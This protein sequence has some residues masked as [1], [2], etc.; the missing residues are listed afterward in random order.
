MADLELTT[1][2]RTLVVT[3]NRPARRNAVDGPTAA[4]L[5]QAFRAFDADDALDVAVLT[6]ADGTFCAGADLKAIAEGKGN[7][8]EHAGDGPMGPTR[9][10]LSKPA[11]AAIE[12]FAVAGGLELATWCDLRVAA[13][14]AVLGVFCRRWGVPLVDLGTVRL[15]RLIGHSRAIDMILTGRGVGAPEALSMGLVNRVVPDGTALEA[16]IELAA[17]LSALPQRCLRSDRLSAI[18]QW[19]LAEADATTNEVDHGLEVLRSGEAIEGAGRFAAGAG[20]HGASELGGGGSAIQHGDALE[21]LGHLEEVEGAECRDVEPDVEE[22]SQVTR[23]RRRVAR[24]RDDAADRR[25]VAQGSEHASI[26]ATSRRIEHDVGDVRRVR[27]DGT[28]ANLGRDD[29]RPGLV[30][31][32]PPRVGSRAARTVD[33]EDRASRAD[34]DRRCLGEESRPAVQVE[35]AVPT[36]ERESMEDLVDQ[37]LGC[38]H[39]DLPEHARSDLVI[40]PVDVRRAILRATALEDP[41]HRP[42]RS[43]SW[44][45]LGH[46]DRRGAP[47]GKSNHLDLRARWPVVRPQRARRVG[48][49]EQEAVVN[50]HELVARVSTHRQPARCVDAESDPRSRSES[51]QLGCDRLDLDVAFER[52]DRAQLLGE[53]LTLERSLR[54]R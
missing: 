54:D 52:G 46:R 12:G 4:L 49:S 47:A 18:E 1:V 43:P 13:Q 39:V 8:V 53:S 42:A 32:V 14:S 26:D 36:L 17:E 22:R 25:D 3:I 21:V 31:E 51:V 40:D 2:A 15:P 27:R 16:A 9:L 5:A 7:R 44:R 10:R 34:R 35:H 33:A 28:R 45:R 11:I 29:R 30:A 38:A 41:R 19:D 20:R 50:G 6:G 23:E 48:I 37:D 24:H